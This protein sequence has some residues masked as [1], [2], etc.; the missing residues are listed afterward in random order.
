MKDG[1]DFLVVYKIIKRYVQ[2][3]TR[4]WANNCSYRQHM[5][6]RKR[7][8]RGATTEDTLPELK[9]PTQR[10][11]TVEKSRKAKPQ[12]NREAATAIAKDVSID[13]YPTATQPKIKSTTCVTTNPLLELQAKFLSNFLTPDERDNFFCEATVSSE[14][15]AQIWTE[16]N[17]VGEELVNQYA[18]ATPDDR[19]LR[20]IRH[21]A[22]IVEIGCGANA[23][24]CRQMRKMGIDVLGFDKS[25][26][27]GGKIQSDHL[28]ESS[29]PTDEEEFTVRSGGPEDL[30][31]H[32]E[33]TLFLCYPDEDVMDND[34]TSES[35]PESMGEACLEH[36]KGNYIIHVGEL[37]L[38]ATHSLEQAPWGRSSSPAFQERLAA[39]YHCILRATL[40]NW[41]HTA[42]RI[43]VWKRSPTTVISFEDDNNETG[44]QQPDSGSMSSREGP[45]EVLYR[46]IPRDERLPVDTA[47]PCV[48]HLLTEALTTEDRPQKNQTDSQSPSRKKNKRKNSKK[49]SKAPSVAS[50]GPYNCPW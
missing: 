35:S 33:R 28:P 38:D 23:Y 24:W 26:N 5:G 17:D 13:A 44:S 48:A 46:H 31:D 25:P 34:D 16:Q 50:E 8:K 49:K 30:S 43:T 15:R 12:T 27:H 45:E 19:A 42:D 7:S 6:K 36:Y 47:A 11:Q 10:E 29:R 20:I 3:A 4:M 32:K 21:F 2:V 14:R 9:N 41:L 40:P 37:F 18:W 39:E 22:P 1:R